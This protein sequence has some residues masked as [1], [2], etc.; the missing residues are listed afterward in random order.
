MQELQ[1]LSLQFV[2]QQ[3]DPR[4]IAAGAGQAGDETSSYL[5]GISI[6]NLLG[7]VLVR[8]SKVTY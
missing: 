3:I 6:G 1:P 4:E 7:K 5:V 8:A 2:G